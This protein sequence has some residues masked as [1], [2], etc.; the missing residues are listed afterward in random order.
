MTNLPC[1]VIRDLLP[2]Y[3]DGVCSEES[4]AAVEAHLESC[5]SCKAEYQRL[6]DAEKLVPKQEINLTQ[7]EEKQIKALRRVKRRLNKRRILAVLLTVIVVVGIGIGLN[8]FGGVLFVILPYDETKM[9]VEPMTPENA[10]KAMLGEVESIEDFVDFQMSEEITEYYSGL[11]GKFFTL[12]EDGKTINAMYI[13]CK[14]SLRSYLMNGGKGNSQDQF[15]PDAPDL[16]PDGYKHWGISTIWARTEFRDGPVELG[17]VDGYNISLVAEPPELSMPY[18]VKMEAPLD[19]LYYLSGPRICFNLSDDRKLV[20]QYGV[21][22][23][24]R[25]E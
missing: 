23:W 20:E 14:S 21:L 15:A 12:E 16:F 10:E 18:I 4:R 2:L 7:A 11:C 5:E 22:I 1:D 3:V 9:R 25:N 17:L 8:F 24:S 13:Y 6:L 19:R